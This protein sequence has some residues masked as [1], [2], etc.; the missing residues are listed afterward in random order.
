MAGKPYRPLMDETVQRLGAVD[1]SSS[2]T[3]WTPT[4]RGRSTAGLD[5]M[6]VLTGSHTVTDLVA[7]EP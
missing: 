6:L 3:G 1:R 4:S 5:S 7:A 2:G